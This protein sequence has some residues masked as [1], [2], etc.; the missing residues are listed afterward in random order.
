MLHG[1]IRAHMAAESAREPSFGAH[2]GHLDTRTYQELSAPGPATFCDHSVVVR[3]TRTALPEADYLTR[4]GQIAYQVSSMEWAI[5]GD[6]TALTPALPADL[7]VASLAGKTTASIAAS[8]RAAARTISVDAVREYIDAAAT[9]LE[10]VGPRRNHLLHARP[11][12][13]DGAQRLYR[14]RAAPGDQFPISLDWLDEQIAAI[15]AAG[16]AMSAHRWA[17]HQAVRSKLR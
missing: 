14:W 10:D 16:E 4:I 13:I 8:L 15:N 6:L 7:T 1:L 5:L 2:P 17:A 3:P 11:A 12:T 9:A